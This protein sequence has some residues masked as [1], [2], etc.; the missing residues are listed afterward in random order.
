M[1]T[2]TDSNNNSRENR[3]TY[4]EMKSLLYHWGLTGITIV[5]WLFWAPKLTGAA[6]LD[7]D[8]PVD[9]GTIATSFEVSYE[10]E[11]G[12]AWEGNREGIIG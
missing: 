3:E 10:S 9:N 2:D 8:V 5:N 11:R 1:D 12:G 7:V 4:K 6:K